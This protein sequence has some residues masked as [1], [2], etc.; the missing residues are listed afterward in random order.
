MSNAVSTF[1]HAALAIPCTSWTKQQRIPKPKVAG[2]HR[3]QRLRPLRGLVLGALRHV[4]AAA[5]AADELLEDLSGIMG[6]GRAHGYSQVSVQPLRPACEAST[7][8]E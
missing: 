5:Q 3:Q 2:S 4:L 6:L 1:H 8:T 7:S